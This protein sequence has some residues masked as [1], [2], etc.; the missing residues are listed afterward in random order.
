MQTADP[1][2]RTSE[3]EDPTNIYAVHPISNRL[4]PLCARLGIPPNAVSVA[5][6]AC[7]LLAGI[8]Y[9]HDRNPWAVV[10]GFLLM[11]AWH[12][13]DGVDGQLARLTGAQSQS[14]K[15]LD[16]MCDYVT[17]TAVYLG[18]ALVLSARHGAWVWALVALSG[19]CHA[20][21]SAIYEV[22]RQEYN[23]WGHG[24][25]SAALPEPTRQPAGG[26]PERLHD[27]YLSVQRLAVCIDGAPRQRLA[28][29]LRQ[30]P[31]RAAAIRR[32]YRET[33]APPVRRWAVLSANARTLGLF[34]C[35]LLRRPLLYF[36]LEIV[37]LSAVLAVL[38]YQQHR[39]SRRFLEGQG[40]CPWTPPKAEP[41]DSLT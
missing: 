9:A 11:L 38:L 17:F 37:V 20:V 13:L 30:D 29:L 2:R 24:R 25:A 39:R 41:L 40:S 21:Q 36:I 15:I 7:G 35:A 23:H 22:Q 4:V 12:V 31:A 1:V 3:I 26:L 33:F 10:A 32:L 8:A 14:G 34:A 6:M 18:L 16:G 27:V 5:G 19:A 28:A